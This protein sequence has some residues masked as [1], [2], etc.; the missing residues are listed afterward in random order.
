M[1]PNMMRTLI[2]AISLISALNAGTITLVD[3]I[4]TGNLFL[5][6]PVLTG[7]GFAF[8]N[9]GPGSILADGFTAP[10]TAVLAQ[11]SVA[12]QYVFL[13]GLSGTYPMEL[14]LFSSSG[15]LPGAAIESWTVP[16]APNTTSLTLVNVISV[17]NAL[18]LAGHQYWLGVVPT[19]ASGT[20]IGWGLASAGYPG[21]QLP[22]ASSAVGSNLWSGGSNNLANEFSVSGTTVPEPASLGIGAL[23]TLSMLMARRKA[24]RS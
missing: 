15:S 18:L 12:V 5:Q 11:I 10:T 21:I 4:P 7:G 16:L 2:L 20:G 3:T 24:L 19:D 1:L 23:I 8:G 22:I 14:T 6:P 13:P 17:T 9:T